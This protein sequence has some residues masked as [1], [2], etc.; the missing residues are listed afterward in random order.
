M[1]W[2]RIQCLRLQILWLLVP[3]CCQ[4]WTL[5]SYYRVTRALKHGSLLSS[6]LPHQHQ[7]TL[8]ST[9][10]IDI[11]CISVAGHDPDRYKANQDAYFCESCQLTDCN[12]TILGVMDGHGTKGHL[13]TDYLRKQLPIRIIQLL[14]HE[15]LM[16]SD[17][18]MLKTL[19]QDL[20][21][22]GRA[23]NDPSVMLDKVVDSNSMNICNDTDTNYASLLTNAF[24]LAHLDAQME[25]GIPAQRSGT[26]CV[27]ALIV[28]SKDES[29][30]GLYIAHVGDSQALWKMTCSSRRGSEEG[31]TAETMSPP[32]YRKTATL[33]ATTPTTTRIPAELNRI[34]NCMRR[35]NGTRIDA[36]GN[37]FYG[38]QGIAMTRSLGNAYML[39]AGI[40]PTPVVTCTKHCP[41]WIIL[42]TDGVSDVL[43]HATIQAIIDGNAASNSDMQSVVERV[44]RRASE[45]W[46][47]GLNMDVKIDDITCIAVKLGT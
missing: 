3:I 2:L 1:A 25:P 17:L 23:T 31:E 37:V 19:Q 38:P 30:N 5:V 10:N 20:V 40:L 13:L 34:E 6:R 11:G 7:D 28:D 41:E 9:A 32:Q 22:V 16:T 44:A 29:T 36:Q 45:A 12:V 15:S 18:E 14:K 24:H 47:G 27:V 35:R 21:R 33:H 26:T 4:G 46:Q 42:M 39:P 8:Q 43:N